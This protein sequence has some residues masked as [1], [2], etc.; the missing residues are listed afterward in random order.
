ML[1]CEGDCF[2]GAVFVSPNAHGAPIVTPFSQAS[3]VETGEG[4]R[5]RWKGRHEQAITLYRKKVTQATGAPVVT[6]FSQASPVSDGGSSYAALSQA[7]P[8]RYGGGGPRK[9]WKGRL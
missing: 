1:R 5:L 8:V 6:P 9:R 4:D 7:S 3:P 2:R